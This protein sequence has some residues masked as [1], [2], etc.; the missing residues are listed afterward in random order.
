MESKGGGGE[1][2]GLNRGCMGKKRGQEVKMSVVDGIFLKERVS[3][4]GKKTK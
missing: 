4:G 1:E 3:V 2:S